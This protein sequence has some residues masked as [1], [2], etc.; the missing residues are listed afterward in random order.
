MNDKLNP[1]LLYIKS[2][3]YNNDWPSTMHTHPFSEIFYVIKGKGNFHIENKV[4]S[5]NEDDLIIVNPNVIHTESSS[6]DPLEYMVV[7]LSKIV[8]MDDAY[9]IQN[10]KEYKHD[11]L[12]YLKTL[13][14]EFLRSD[15][16]TNVICDNLL[17]ILIYNIIRYSNKKFG[18]ITSANL[19]DY[20]I[21]QA[22][23]F[24][25][26]N[27]NKK[28]TLEDIA[29][30]LYLSKYYLAHIFKKQLKISPIRYLLNF[31]LK[32]AK[33]YLLNTSYSISDIAV[34][35]GFENSAYFS[36][37]FKKE[38]KISPSEYRNK[39]GVNK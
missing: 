28:I 32:K 35:V 23:S 19:L 1:E 33:E 11:I 22:C 4:I 2:Y 7:G 10:F 14:I 16:Y 38:F 36:N 20:K 9:L 8:L 27:F 34:I 29:L 25:E 13:S 21:T 3:R 37:T 17:E 24:I 39:K 31:R 30:S 18:D 5:V 12:L 26:N 6:N 15:H